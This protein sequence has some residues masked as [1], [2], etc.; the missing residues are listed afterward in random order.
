MFTITN[1]QETQIKTA[2]RYQLTSVKMAFIKKTK[3]M[4]AGKD[5]KKRE[6]SY[7]VFG[8]VN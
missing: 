8:N 1:H 7:T 2:T 3:L 5:V 6:H 4:D